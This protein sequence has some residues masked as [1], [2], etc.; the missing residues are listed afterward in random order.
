MTE[1]IKVAAWRNK[2]YPDQVEF[3]C[4]IGC[5]TRYKKDGAPCSNSKR[6]IHKHYSPKSSNEKTIQRHP[7][8]DTQI[9]ID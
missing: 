4:P 6:K 7:H 1:V 8:C 5:H 9:Q 3:T 2:K